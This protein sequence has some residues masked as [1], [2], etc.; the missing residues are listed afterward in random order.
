MEDNNKLVK[1][2][3]IGAFVGAAISLFDRETRKNTAITVKDC[4]QKIWKCAKDPSKMIENIS[5]KLSSTRAKVEEFTEDIQYIINKV[6]D[7]KNSTQN[8]TNN[9]NYEKINNKK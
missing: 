3:L 7:I 5:N 2:M 6:N 4:S 1:G 8:L 9:D